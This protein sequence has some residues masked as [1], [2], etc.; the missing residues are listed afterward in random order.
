MGEGIEIPLGTWP[1][2]ETHCR[3]EFPGDGFHIDN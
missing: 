2:F 3:H 1:G